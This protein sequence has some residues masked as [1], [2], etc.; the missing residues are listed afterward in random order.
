MHGDTLGVLFYLYTCVFVRVWVQ[1]LVDTIP[2]SNNKALVL[3]KSSGKKVFMCLYKRFLLKSYGGEL[4][5]KAS[6]SMA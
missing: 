3:R 1:G 6:I 4:K 2:I 5:S